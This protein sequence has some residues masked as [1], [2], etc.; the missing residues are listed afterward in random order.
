MPVELAPEVMAFYPSTVDES[1]RLSS[2]ADGRLEM[3]RT[4]ELLR[5]YLPPAPARILDIGGGPGS[6]ARWLVKAGYT[7]HLVDLAFITA[8]ESTAAGEPGHGAFDGPPVPSKPRCGLGALAGDAVADTALGHPARTRSAGRATAG[9]GG[10][11]SSVG[12]FRRTRAPGAAPW[13][14][15]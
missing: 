2:S 10:E 7:V 6:H 15:K 11:P 1:I 5:R 12:Q 4:Q 13:L 3:V 14:A 8:V 9:L